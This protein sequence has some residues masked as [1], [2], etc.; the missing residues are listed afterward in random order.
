MIQIVIFSFNR[1]MQLASLLESIFQHDNTCLLDIAVVY[2]YSSTLH[3]EG[4]EL[5]KKKYPAIAWK[6]ETLTS[7]P[8]YNFEFNFFNLRNWFWWFK[9]SGLRKKKSDFKRVLLRIIEKTKHNFLMFL[10][11]DSLF[12]RNIHIPQDCIQKILDTSG[13]T[14]F[15]LRHGANLEGGVYSIEKD[16]IQWNMYDNDKNTDWGYPFSVDGHIYLKNAIAPI[17]EKTIYNNPNT[18]ESNLCFYILKN[19]LFPYGIA[20]KESCLV[21]FELNRVQNVFQNNH[22]NIS[23]DQLNEYFMNNYSLSIDFIFER[24]FHFHPQIKS[25]CV[26]KGNEKI[27]LLS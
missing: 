14:S 21:G 7:R 22:L 8:E 24:N 4:Y 17:L 1:A 27:T 10:T 5:L 18:L 13:K 15:S 11:D 3:E 6:K 2:A 25:V 12:Y 26:V 19:R 16:V 23:T 20:N 9:Y